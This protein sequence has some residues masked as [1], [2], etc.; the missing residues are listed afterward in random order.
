MSQEQNEKSQEHQQEQEQN[1]IVKNDG[2]PFE[3]EQGANLAMGRK[4]LSSDLYHIGAYKTG[5]AIF[6]SPDA[7]VKS[8]DNMQHDVSEALKNAEYFRVVFQQ[9]SS[10]NDER[11]VILSL[12][13]ASLVI[14]RGVETIIPKAYKEIADHAVV[15]QHQQLAGQSRKKIGL[16]LTYPYV[17]IGIATK[18]QY[19]AMKRDGDA[20]TRAELKRIETEGVAR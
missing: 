9:K 19:E 10:P 4:R 1:V 6:A 12:N 20:T 5:F 11:D 13:G 16:R 2:T 8:N 15:E 17:P 18:Q 14:P 3:T 7:G